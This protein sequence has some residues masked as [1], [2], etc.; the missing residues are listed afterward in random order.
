MAGNCAECLFV[1]NLELK[2]LSASCRGSGRFCGVEPNISHHLRNHEG[3]CPLKFLAILL[4]LTH[5]RMLK[6]LTIVTTWTAIKYPECS[7]TVS[8]A[9]VCSKDHL[10]KTGYYSEQYPHLQSWHPSYY[11]LHSPEHY[12]ELPLRKARGQYTVH[13]Q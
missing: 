4:Q 2:Y 12:A 7:R 6:I 1:W 13:K 5:F 10:Y 9:L 11:P 3:I 8:D